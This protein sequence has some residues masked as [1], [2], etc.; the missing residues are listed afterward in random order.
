MQLFPPA[1]VH[2]LAWT[3]IILSVELHQIKILRWVF[4]GNSE[5]RMNH[6]AFL[7]ISNFLQFY[8]MPSRLQSSSGVVGGKP[9][10][11]DEVFLLIYSMR[12]RQRPSIKFNNRSS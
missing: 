3:V 5:L 1:V 2:P 12:L 8:C 10:L 9:L 6:V 4:V 11:S 7:P